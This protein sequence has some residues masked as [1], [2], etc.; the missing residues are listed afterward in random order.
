MLRALCECLQI[1]GAKNSVVFENSHT[2]K[3]ICISFIIN[4]KNFN[5]FTRRCFDEI[6][7]P[8]PS[9]TTFTQ[10]VHALMEQ[11]FGEL[12]LAMR[13]PPYSQAFFPFR[14]KDGCSSIVEL[15]KDILFYIPSLVGLPR[16]GNT[17]A[18]IIH[19]QIYFIQ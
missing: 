1:R 2:L 5:T 16:T 3:M 8:A 19:I 15:V 18:M 11:D 7:I 14:P 17:E 10:F 4:K 12:L 6:L 9:P 13:K